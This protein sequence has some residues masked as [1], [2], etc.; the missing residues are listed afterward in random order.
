MKLSDVEF[1]ALLHLM[2]A[3]DPWPGTEEEND[4]LIALLDNESIAHGYDNWI[5]AFHE[6]QSPSKA[7][8]T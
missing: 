4:I 8:T 6:F 5:V 3:S 7:Q 2:M 1:R